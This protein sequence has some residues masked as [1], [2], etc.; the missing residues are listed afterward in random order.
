MVLMAHDI[1]MI[2]DDLSPDYVIRII[3][4]TI[5]IPFRLASLYC[6]LALPIYLSNICSDISNI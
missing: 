4:G 5:F 3:S 1:E 2:D 6:G